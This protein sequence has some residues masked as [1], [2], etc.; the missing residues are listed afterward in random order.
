MESAR[1][2]T[3]P[4]PLE[5]GGGGRKESEPEN[6]FSA[7]GFPRWKEKLTISVGEMLGEA[8][9]KYFSGWNLIYYTEGVLVLFVGALLHI[10]ASVSASGNPIAAPF[11]RLIYHTLIIAMCMLAWRLMAPDIW[12]NEDFS[13]WTLI[14]SVSFGVASAITYIREMHQGP[15]IVVPIIFALIRTGI[16]IQANLI[17]PVRV[18]ARAKNINLSKCSRCDHLNLWGMAAIVTIGHLGWAVIPFQFDI[19]AWLYLG[20][21]FLSGCTGLGM[22]FQSSLG[23]AQQLAA[24][25]LC[26][27]GMTYAS[28]VIIIVF[29]VLRSALKSVSLNNPVIGLVYFYITVFMFLNLIWEMTKI[30]T[31]R[32][33][34]A[35]LLAIFPLQFFEEIAISLLFSD[36]GGFSVSFFVLLGVVMIVDF[37]VESGWFWENYFI[38][39]KADQSAVSKGVYMFKIFQY[40]RQKNFAERFATPT[41]LLMIFIEWLANGRYGLTLISDTIDAR[42]QS[43]KALIFGAYG[44]LIA[45]ENITGYFSYRILKKRMF[46]LKKAANEES[47]KLCRACAMINEKPLPDVCAHD[48]PNVVYGVHEPLAVCTHTRSEALHGLGAT[49]SPKPECKRKSIATSQMVTRSPKQS[50]H[51]LSPHHN[52]NATQGSIG[53]SDHDI[54]SSKDIEAGKDVNVTESKELKIETTRDIETLESPRA[55]TPRRRPPPMPQNTSWVVSYRYNVDGFRHAMYYADAFPGLSP[56]AKVSR[57]GFLS[58]IILHR[59]LILISA[60]LNISAIH[61]LFQDN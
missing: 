57:S 23:Y 18:Y 12:E 52:K 5:E 21:A 59:P 56:D 27:I 6:K 41:F 49:G 47:N 37:S 55:S 60:L 24:I 19:S 51:L 44:V 22:M 46:R 36:A 7:H 17:W 28:G 34:E 8:R 31:Y 9:K 32:R 16:A 50:Q 58:R 14:Y 11:W 30:V 54:K 4:P 3:T 48:F 61:L 42:T 33:R 29:A 53:F 2:K 13:K 1:E 26:T 40:I 10:L 20:L 39:M 45:C 38:L 43:K 15:V 35:L 25:I